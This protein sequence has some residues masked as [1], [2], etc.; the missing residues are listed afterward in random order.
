LDLVKEGKYDPS[1]VFTH[2][3]KRNPLHKLDPRNALT[4]MVFEDDF[5][6]VP[7]EYEKQ[8]THEVPGGLKS[9]MVTPYGRS[10]NQPL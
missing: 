2:T 6:N 10:L 5:E 9:I 3:G 4:T 8:F 1:F 7:E